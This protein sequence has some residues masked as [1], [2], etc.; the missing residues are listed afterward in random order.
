M[1]DPSAI[2]TFFRPKR[3][4]VGMIKIITALVTYTVVLKSFLILTID[5]CL[6][7]NH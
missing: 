2:Q 3:Y 7:F 4:V 6:T 5:D 1:L